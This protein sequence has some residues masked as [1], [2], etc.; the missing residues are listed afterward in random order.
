MKIIPVKLKN[1]LS[2]QIA[3]VT[4]ICKMV[5]IAFT[6]VSDIYVSHSKQYSHSASDIIHKASWTRKNGIKIKNMTY[7]SR[8]F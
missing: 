8:L 3:P 1:F 6:P 2:L 4:D 5:K 7:C